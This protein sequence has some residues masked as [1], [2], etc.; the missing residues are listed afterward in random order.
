MGIS[1]PG[2]PDGMFVVRKVCQKVCQRVDG[3]QNSGSGWPENEA[4]FAGKVR[5]V[6]GLTGRRAMSKT[7]HLGTVGCQKSDRKRRKSLKTERKADASR[8]KR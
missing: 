6:D 3:R 4:E 8:R 1:A 2:A 5:Q 7:A